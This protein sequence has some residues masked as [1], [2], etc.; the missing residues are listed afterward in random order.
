VSFTPAPLHALKF[1]R[2]AAS[3]LS[4]GRQATVRRMRKKLSR[5]A[6]V[7]CRPPN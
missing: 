2:K 4:R 7:L 5:A 1:S 3:S 6:A